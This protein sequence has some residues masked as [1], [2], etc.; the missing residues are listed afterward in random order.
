MMLRHT[1]FALLALFACTEAFNA[2]VSV[3]ATRTAVRAAD[4]LMFGGGKKSTPKVAPA[5]KAAPKPAAKRA[6]APKRSS[7]KVGGLFYN[8]VGAMSS[9]SGKEDRFGNRK[10]GT[11]KKS[12]YP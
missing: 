8:G 7:S 12:L 3:I 5:A 11:S 6:A 10:F 1:L 9:M 4:P 2:P